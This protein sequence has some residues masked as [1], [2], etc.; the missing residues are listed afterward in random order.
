MAE[1]AQLHGA[2]IAARPHALA[3]PLARP[4]GAT[5]SLDRYNPLPLLQYHFF[6][7]NGLTAGSCC[8]FTFL[9]IRP[10]C[11]AL[12]AEAP[13]SDPSWSV[14][15]L[16]ASR[17]VE[18]GLEVLAIWVHVQLSPVD[19]SPADDRNPIRRIRCCDA[20]S[21]RLDCAIVKS[22]ATGTSMYLLQYCGSIAGLC[23]PTRK[24]RIPCQRRAPS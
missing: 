20:A 17:N 23:K 22:D 15:S 8:S 2:A 5:T 19:R 12:F 13:V 10:C 14:S 6:W 4:Q 16:Q 24:M 3:T 21:D 9:A 1:R 11:S 18:P 7:P